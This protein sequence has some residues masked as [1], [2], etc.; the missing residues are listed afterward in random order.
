VARAEVLRSPGEALEAGRLA[1]GQNATL[2]TGASEY[3]SPGHPLRS[4]SFGISTQSSSFLRRSAPEP[5]ANGRPFR[6]IGW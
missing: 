2:F 4:K 1:E 6:R 3:L 5:I